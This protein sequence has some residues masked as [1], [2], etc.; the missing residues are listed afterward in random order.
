MTPN[1]IQEDAVL[2]ALR[3]LRT[4]DVAPARAQRLR[5]RCHK[6][7]EKWSSGETLTWRQ[8]VGLLA[9]VWC[10]VY[11]LETIRLAAAIYGF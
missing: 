5:I 7:I 10:L 4:Y 8:A 11:A 6:D 9:S 3:D 1:N 2:A